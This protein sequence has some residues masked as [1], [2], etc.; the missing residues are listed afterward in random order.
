MHDSDGHLSKRYW[1]QLKSIRFTR[2]LRRTFYFPS[3]LQKASKCIGQNTIPGLCDF[4][5]FTLTGNRSTPMKTYSKLKVRYTIC[6]KSAQ[7][8]SRNPSRTL[9]KVNLLHCVAPAAET[10][11]K[12]VETVKS[13]SRAKTL[14]NLEENLI[15]CCQGTVPPE[16]AKTLIKF[17]ENVEFMKMMKPL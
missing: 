10:L 11:I 4:T 8:A 12:H 9:S 2:F 7:K 16:M 6:V 1:N 5:K 14:I 17:A 15:F 3:P 13:W